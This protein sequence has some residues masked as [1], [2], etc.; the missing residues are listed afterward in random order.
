MVSP[1]SV[2]TRQSEHVFGDI[3]KNQVGG[4]RRDLIKT[5]LAEF[6]LDVILFSKAESTIGLDRGVGRF[7]GCVRRQQF[8]HVGL[9]SAWLVRIKQRRSAPDHQRRSFNIC[10]S[11][12]KRELNALVLPN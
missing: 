3:S 1:A 5:S 2:G 7:P 12:G 9:R 8:G 11:A 4:D 10:I 6:T